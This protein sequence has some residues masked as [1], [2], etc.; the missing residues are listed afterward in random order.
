MPP[1]KLSRWYK[2]ERWLQ[3]KGHYK[4]VRFMLFVGM[5]RRNRQHN[6]E[7]APK[8][9]ASL[10]HDVCRVASVTLFPYYVSDTSP[11]RLGI[12]QH[13]LVSALCE[14]RSCQDVFVPW[15]PYIRAAVRHAEWARNLIWHVTPESI[16]KAEATLE[17]AQEWNHA[18]VVGMDLERVE[19]YEKMSKL[20]K[21]AGMDHFV[22]VTA[23]Q[24]ELDLW[25]KPLSVRLAEKEG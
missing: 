7:Q 10:L 6:R 11:E 8:F 3:E 5:L 19:I 15:H 18:K 1:A 9:R 14:L 20:C 21:G 22:P 4:V 13:H 16:K 12:A 17:E 24:S 25:F 2:F 23:I